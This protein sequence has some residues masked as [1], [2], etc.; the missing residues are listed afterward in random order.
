MAERMKAR[1][2]GLRT[3]LETTVSDGRIGFTEGVSAQ[4]GDSDI[5]DRIERSRETLNK[6]ADR[7]QKDLIDRVIRNGTKGLYRM[8]EGSLESMPDLP[9]A[10]DALEV[11]AKTDG[12]RPSFLVRNGAPDRDSSPVGTW[13][14]M[15]D[16]NEAW[17]RRAIAGVGR[18][19]VPGGPPGFM[20]T[21]F[22]VSPDLI[23]TNRHVLQAIAT[24]TSPGTWE[25]FPD[26]AIDFGHE[27]NAR[28]SV[29]RRR[30]RRV[31]FAG[32]KFIVSNAIDHTKLDLA[33][34]ELEPAADGGPDQTPLGLALKPAPWTDPGAVVCIVGYPGSPPPFAYPPSLLDQLFHTTFGYKRLAPGMV[35]AGADGVAPWTVSHDATTLGGNS[36][37][38]ILAIGNDGLAV[39]L[40][41][42]GHSSPPAVNW[43]HKLEGV[44]GQTDGHSAATLT[45]VLSRYGVRVQGGTTP[46][47]NGGTTPRTKGETAR[48]D[49]NGRATVVRLESMRPLATFRT[50]L[51]VLEAS[52]NGVTPPEAFEGRGGYD[53]NFLDGFPIPLPMPGGDVRMLRRSGSAAELKYEH[54]SVVMSA[55]RRMPKVTACNIDGSESRRLPRVQAWKFDGRLN[56]EDQWGNDLYV[57]NDLDK[58]HMVRREDPVWGTQAVASQANVDTFHYTNSCPQMAVVNQQI[59][60][61][62][63]NYVLNHTRDDEMRVT[64]FTGPYFTEHD[65][66]YRGALVPRAFWK[67]VA[68]LLPDGRPSATAYR[69]SQDR[70]LQDLEFV[71]AGYSTFQISIKQVADDTG[72]NFDA[73]LP[74]DGFSQH[75]LAGNPPVVE[76]IDRIERI[77]V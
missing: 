72:I 67:V 10:L 20:G 25:L 52:Q 17:L 21:G 33:L 51:E 76:R 26:L 46:R 64:V 55:S 3:I 38:V 77:R 9:Q 75:E 30:L 13:G 57:N 15:L 62:L 41:Y 48:R 50:S 69:V 63:E 18:I 45:E 54:F 37:S 56:R 19:D 40:H 71:F 16:G 49:G 14:P 28:A 65:L 1:A 5:K 58:G 29:T 27:F 44:L 7:R 53:P 39:G 68:F 34:I 35:V 31:V 47:T 2:A 32:S 70:E 59:W 60:A 22:L 36:G 24:E 4:L 43:G 12:S 74:Y 73:L 66:P 42:G 6:Y 11:I 8:A 61:G 23:V